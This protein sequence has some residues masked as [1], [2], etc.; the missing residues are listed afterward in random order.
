MFDW[1]PRPLALSLG[2]VLPGHCRALSWLR[3]QLPGMAPLAPMREP[4]F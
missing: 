2:L 3:A 4:L 1:M